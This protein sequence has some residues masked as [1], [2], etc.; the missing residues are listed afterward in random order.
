MLRIH[1]QYC[2]LSLPLHVDYFFVLIETKDRYKFGRYMALAPNDPN[3]LSAERPA[4]EQKLSLVLERTSRMNVYWKETT[5]HTL[6]F[7]VEYILEDC[8]TFGIRSGNITLR[9]FLR[10]MKGIKSI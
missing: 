9:C 3:L 1:L 8:L 5:W 6:L 10:Y 4:E 2:Y 7:H